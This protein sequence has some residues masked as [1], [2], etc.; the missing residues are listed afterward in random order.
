MT[1][2]R[3]KRRNWPVKGTQGLVLLTLR[4]QP[5]G[6]RVPELALVVSKTEPSVWL[7]LA[8]LSERG[9]VQSVAG[10]VSVTRA[11]RQLRL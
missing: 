6:I 2:H 8:G 4:G 10:T 5:Q 9:L 1:I 11:G 3:L 7:A